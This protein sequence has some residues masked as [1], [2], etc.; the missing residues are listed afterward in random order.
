MEFKAKDV[1]ALFTLGGLFTLIGLG[2]I[3]WMQASPII[4][5]IVFYYLGFKSG[6][7]YAR[8]KK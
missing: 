3:T 2:K 5:G 1:I 7:A 6:E 4:S 8:R